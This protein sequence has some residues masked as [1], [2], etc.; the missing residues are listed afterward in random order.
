MMDGESSDQISGQHDGACWVCSLSS[1]LTTTSL[2]NKW[3][4]GGGQG[5]WEPK[6]KGM[7]RICFSIRGREEK[8]SLQYKEVIPW[9]QSS[10]VS[11]F[12]IFLHLKYS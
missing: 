10:L 6:I 4:E 2:N 8:I 9:S 12:N 11:L 5:V 7:S 1:P 3:V